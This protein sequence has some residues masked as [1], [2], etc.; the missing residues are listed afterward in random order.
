M[1][2]PAERRCDGTLVW[3][4]VDMKPNPTDMQKENAG[5]LECSICGFY[6][7]TGNFYPESHADND[8]IME[9]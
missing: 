3:F 8:L 4:H 5:I 7:C 6:Q 1:S 9:T 2:S